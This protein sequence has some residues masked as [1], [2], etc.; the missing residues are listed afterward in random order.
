MNQLDTATVFQTPRGTIACRPGID[1]K[2]ILHLSTHGG[3][4]ASDF[5]I[6][7]SRIHP[8]DTVLDIGA[9]IGAFTVA[10]ATSARSVHAFEPIPTNADQLEKN[11]RLNHL[12][13]VVV[14]RVG[15]ADA[16]GRLY[17]QQTQDAGEI[18]LTQKEG[19]LV[20]P[21]QTLDAL[22]AT[23]KISCIKIDV[24][25]MEERVLHGGAQVIRNSRPSIFF[26]V[27]K[28]HM[29]VYD[30]TL[31]GLAR[32]MSGYAFFFNLTTAQNGEYVLGRLP[33]LGVLRF[34]S[35]TLNVLGVPNE[36]VDFAYTGQFQTLLRLVLRKIKNRL[37]AIL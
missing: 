13:N 34:A 36:K 4:M 14:H 7:Q 27:Q 37:Q 1:L 25:G 11:I 16:A 15:L 28:D 32:T 12:T 18:F 2:S 19:G 8:Q 9:N 20:V 31:R 33:W 23:E 35:G 26:E 5:A 21:V 17:A 10:L 22:F 24:E 29:R 3:F 6:M 30:A